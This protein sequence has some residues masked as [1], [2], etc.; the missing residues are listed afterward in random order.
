MTQ[1]SELYYRFEDHLEGSGGYDIHGEWEPG[2]SRTIVKLYSFE[3]RRHTPKGVWIWDNHQN[4]AERFICHTWTKRFALPSIEEAKLSFIKRKE[5][6]A[7]IYEARART[8][9]EAIALAQANSYRGLGA[10]WNSSHQL[11]VIAPSISRT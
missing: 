6:Q 10:P 5:R 9:R 2:P 1:T 8:A 7:G 3:V 11:G 4:G